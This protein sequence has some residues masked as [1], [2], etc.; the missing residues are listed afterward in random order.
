[1]RSS[2][3]ASMGDDTRHPSTPAE[4]CQPEAAPGLTVTEQ[5]S[6]RAA[7]QEP[8]YGRSTAAPQHFF[9]DEM[10]Y[11]HR[12]ASFDMSSMAQSLPQTH[13]RTQTYGHGGPRYAGQAPMLDLSQY[14]A[15]GGMGAIPAQ[16]Y[17]AP[18]HNPMASLYQPPM[19]NQPSSTMAPR[20]DLGYYT[21][22]LVMN[23]QAAHVGPHFYYQLA[24][25]FPGQPSHPVQFQGQPPLDQYRAPLNSHHQYPNSGLRQVQHGGPQELGATPPSPPVNGECFGNIRQCPGIFGTNSSPS[26]EPRSAGA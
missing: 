7:S 17:Y 20:P 11:P 21:S 5:P 4:S 6:S 3:G 8:Q 22:P 25:H 19:T 12:T 1:V 9:T 15:S 26:Q 10:T 18:Q 24:A 23:S 16:S 14:G 2:V 13:Y